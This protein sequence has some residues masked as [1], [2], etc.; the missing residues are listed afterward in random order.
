MSNSKMKPVK[1][2]KS[3]V[4]P[5]V[6]NQEKT[7]KLEHGKVI[8]MTLVTRIMVIIVLLRWAPGSNL[9]ENDNDQYL[10][11]SEN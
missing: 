7:P 3:K 11:N 1:T 6:K 10:R 4:E 9:T 2:K 8:K 5:K